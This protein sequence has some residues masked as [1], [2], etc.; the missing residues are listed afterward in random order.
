MNPGTRVSFTYKGL[1]H[2]G[3]ISEQHGPVIRV[4]FWSNGKYIM[5]PMQASDCK[6]VEVTDDEE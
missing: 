6:V 5:L 2:Q 3:T 4:S 1:P